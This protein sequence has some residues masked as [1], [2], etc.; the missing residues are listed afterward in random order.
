MF[1]INKHFS[2][3]MISLTVFGLITA[4]YAYSEQNEIRSL[5]DMST[6]ERWSNGNMVFAVAIAPK[7]HDAKEFTEEYIK[8]MDSQSHTTQYFTEE[9]L[10]EMLPYLWPAH[11]S[12]DWC[13]GKDIQRGVVVFDNKDIVFW[14]SCAPELIVFE[15][16]EYPGS[17]GFKKDNQ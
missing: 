3:L 10:R 17:F 4:P 14:H 15:G 8:E 16:K 6:F 9:S 2:C 12:V 11:I 13:E 5:H 1:G 7:E